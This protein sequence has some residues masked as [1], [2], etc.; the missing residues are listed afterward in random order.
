M[1]IFSIHM[2]KINS[3]DNQNLKYI[4]Y[5]ERSK[6]HPK[7]ITGSAKYGSKIQH[8]GSHMHY[9]RNKIET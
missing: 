5:T 7:E 1:H 2:H 4:I 6:S 9:M 8:T 3:Q